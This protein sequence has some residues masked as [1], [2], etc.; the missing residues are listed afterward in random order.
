MLL[1][2]VGTNSNGVAVL[3]STGSVFKLHNVSDNNGQFIMLDGT[4]EQKPLM[5]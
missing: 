2:G 5:K 4:L 1:N 3:F